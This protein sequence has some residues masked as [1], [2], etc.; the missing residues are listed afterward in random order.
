MKM[1]FRGQNMHVYFE[2]IYSILRITIYVKFLKKRNSYNSNVFRFEWSTSSLKRKLNYFITEDAF[3]CNRNIHI[4]FE[5]KK[6]LSVNYPPSS[7]DRM[8]ILWPIDR[9]HTI[10]R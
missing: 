3:L 2:E 10:D 6:L 9:A 1:H 5:K 4:L 7:S 8:L